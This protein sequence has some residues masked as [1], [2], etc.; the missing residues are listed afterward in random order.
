MGFEISLFSRKQV[1]R[2]TTQ[3]K[4]KLDKQNK[5]KNQP[6]STLPIQIQSTKFFLAGNHNH[7]Q[8]FSYRRKGFKKRPKMFLSICLLLNQQS[9]S[10][11]EQNLW[12]ASY[13]A[14]Y[15]NRS[16]S[17]SQCQRVQHSKKI[18]YYDSKPLRIEV[19]R[20]VAS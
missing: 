12:R 4:S 6:L 16:W 9:P 17:W 2:S 3:S 7:H 20:V 13:S 11:K 19:T 14:P 5:K 8:L 1:P 10:S 18:S 15:L